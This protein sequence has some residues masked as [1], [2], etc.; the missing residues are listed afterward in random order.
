MDKKSIIEEIKKLTL[1]D[2]SWILDWVKD[3][4]SSKYD[5]KYI[6]VIIHPGE[7]LTQKI[8]KET[9]FYCY[10]KHS[11]QQYTAGRGT[12]YI[13]IPKEQ[14]TEE[15]KKKLIEKYDDKW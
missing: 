12:H 11:V 9:G 13:V 15:L 8:K 10:H 7:N 14:F 2:V 5:E 1:E 6:R 3:I 4:Q